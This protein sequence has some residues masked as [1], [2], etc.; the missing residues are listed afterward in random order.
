MEQ[1]RL[2][3]AIGLSFL[4]FF[5]WDA[6]FVEKEPVKPVAACSNYLCRKGTG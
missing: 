4:V 2:I 3:I 6:F 1:V 5:I